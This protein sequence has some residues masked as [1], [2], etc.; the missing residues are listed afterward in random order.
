MKFLQA[1]RTDRGGGKDPG[2]GG[3]RVGKR[4]LAEQ[5]TRL[6]GGDEKAAAATGGGAQ[7]GE[8]QQPTGTGSAPKAQGAE[9]AEGEQKTESDAAMAQAKASSPL[10]Y[11]VN[12]GARGAGEALPDAVQAKM[13]EQLGADFSGV[14]VHNDG[15]ADQI[16]AHAFTQGD[17]IH[18]AQG[19]F[20]PSSQDG[21]ALLGHELQH[22]VQQKEG[23]VGSPT[24]GGEGN[25][26]V[27]QDPGLEA[28]A[29]AK[30]AAAAQAS[31]ADGAHI[32]AS[33]GAST[34]PVQ[35]KAAS[36]S[37][38][39]MKPA[40]LGAIPAALAAAGAALSSATAAQAA[41]VAG[42]VITGMTTVA[43]MAA[44]VNSGVATY[45]F[46]AWFSQQDKLKLE[47]IAQVRLINAYVDQWLAAHPGESVTNES[48]TTTTTTNTTRRGNTTTRTQ[49]TDTGGGPAAEG[50]QVDS[51]LMETVKTN[52][53]SQITTALNSRQRTASSSEYIWSDSGEHTADAMGTVGAL[54]FQGMRGTRFS[55]SLALNSNASQIAALRTVPLLGE[56]MDVR[57]FRSGRLVQGSSHSTGWGDSLSVNVVGGKEEHDEAANGEHGETRLSTQWQWDGNATQMSIG[58]TIDSSGTPSFGTPEWSGTPDDSSWF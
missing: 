15:Q 43:G 33:A 52:V 42:T 58:I 53:Q 40:I 8:A 44:P 3:R 48:D 55:E 10:S 31:M 20:D 25:A 28:E 56:T 30:G 9:Q 46:D 7:A 23:R 47:R 49:T 39:Q 1:Q 36:G 19:R 6:S 57:E 26:T 22:V 14:R 38:A 50:S 4:T 16:G 51:T 29:D 21:L 54:Q 27:L 35:Q 11:D 34:T 13:G 17:D 12:L 41:T 24:S 18:F 32:L 45:V 37:V 5:L 2:G